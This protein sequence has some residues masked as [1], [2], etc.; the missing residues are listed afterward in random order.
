MEIVIIHKA[1]ADT[2]SV[3]FPDLSKADPVSYIVSSFNYVAG[4]IAALVVL[5]ALWGVIKL[6][7][8]PGSSSDKSES[9]GIFWNLLIGVLFFALIYF[10]FVNIL[11]PDLGNLTLPSLTPLNNAATTAPTGQAGTCGGSISANCPNPSTQACINQGTAGNP[12][13]QCVAISSFDCGVPPN[14]PGQCMTGTCTRTDHDET[15][16]NPT[17]GCSGR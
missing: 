16:K 15:N 5:V 4:F 9:R 12:N 11:S 7:A 10:F 13:Y 14:H 17:Y 6:M 3:F 8:H 2:T 1:F